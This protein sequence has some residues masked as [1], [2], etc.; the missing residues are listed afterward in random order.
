M[1]RPRP[2]RTRPHVDVR[3]QWDYDNP[4]EFSSVSE[5]GVRMIRKNACA[6]TK[7]ASC[8]VGVMPMRI[9]KNKKNAIRMKVTKT[10]NHPTN[11]T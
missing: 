10:Q 6:W 7:K 11:I 9:T 3:Q 5:N 1:D 4:C 2:V 8:V